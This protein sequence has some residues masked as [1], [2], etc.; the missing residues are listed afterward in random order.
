MREVFNG[1]RFVVRTGGQ[2]R[3]RPHDLPPWDIVYQQSR[4]GLNAGSFEAIVHDLRTRLRLAAGR[5]PEPT[6]ATLDSR[7]LQSTPESGGPGGGSW[8]ATSP[9]PRLRAAGEDADGRPLRRRRAP[10][11][12]EGHARV[13]RPLSDTEP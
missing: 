10:G 1:L 13:D 4:R 3:M 7:T 12:G 8:S 5:A 11:L 2:W 6:A 9:G